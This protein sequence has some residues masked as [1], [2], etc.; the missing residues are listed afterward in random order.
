MDAAEALDRFMVDGYPDERLFA[1]TITSVINAAQQGGQ[2]VRAFG[3]MVALLWASGERDATVRLEQMW[4]TVCHEKGLSLFCAYPRNGNAQDATRAFA[5][6][7]ALHS[8]VIATRDNDR[9]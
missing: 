7:C 6:I 3:E 9:P 5:D 4:N 1:E 2:R 8:H